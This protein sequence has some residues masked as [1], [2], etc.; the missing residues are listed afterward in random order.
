MKNIYVSEIGPWTIY[1]E[2]CVQETGT[3]V[4][5]TLFF[6]SCPATAHGETDS[7]ES[8]IAAALDVIAGKTP[9]LLGRVTPSI[10]FIVTRKG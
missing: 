1:L 8:A 7:I 2:E 3:H 6:R 4:S 5:W 10:R 9:R